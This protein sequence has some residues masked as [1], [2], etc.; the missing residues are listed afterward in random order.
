MIGTTITEFIIQ[1]QRH[2]VGATGEFSSLINDIVIACKAIASAVK[3]GKLSAMDVLGSADTE[4]V[5]GETQKKLDV[6]SNELFLRRNEFS[7]HVAAMASE[8]MDDI[9][10]LPPQFPRGKYLLVF[11]PLDGSSNIDVNGAL[12]TIFSILRHPEPGVEPTVAHFL[13]PG[14]QQVCAGY[15]LYGPSTM[16]VLTTGHGV[17]G[18]TLDQRIGEFVLSHPD[19]QAPEDTKEFSINAAYLRAWEPPVKRYIDECLDGKQGPRGKDFNMRW[20]GAMIADVHRVLTRGGVFLYPVDS[21]MRA[22]GVNGKL[23]LL[24]EANPMSFIAEQAGALATTGT[25]RIMEIQPDNLH[26]RCSVIMGSRNEVER[27]IAYH[28]EA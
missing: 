17:N 14:T 8:E 2:H 15:A 19:L 4:N 13:Q 11:D 27:L 28:R 24:Y 3:Y 6:I 9:F 22:K 20:A 1:E 21:R 23:R 5:Q 26:Q 10:N 16:I 7:G 18:F 12:G 25:E